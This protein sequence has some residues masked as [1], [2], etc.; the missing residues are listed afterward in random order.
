MKMG[1]VR[2]AAAEVSFY[3]ACDFRRKMLG[4]AAWDKRDIE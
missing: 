3:P 4:N 1:K 2:A